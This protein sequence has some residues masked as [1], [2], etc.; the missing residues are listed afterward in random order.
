MPAVDLPQK[1][2]DAQPHVAPGGAV[3]GLAPQTE[4]E[5]KRMW[6]LGLAG[7]VLLWA[8]FPPLGWSLLAW[9]API[10]WLLLAR[11]ERLAARRPYRL[12]WVI[13]F[14]HWLAVLQ[15]IRL[16]HWA[17][18][19]GWVTLAAY[20]AIYVPLFVGLTRIAVHR[21][22][23]PL[24][25]AAPVVWT[26]L[27]YARGYVATGF[28]MALLG[29][30]QMRWTTLIQIS[31]LF[32]AYGVTFLVM[33]VAACLASCLPSSWSLW[34]EPR[35]WNWRPLAPL[36]LLVAAALG[37][38]FYRTSQPASDPARPAM[39]AALIQGWVDTI[40]EYDPERDVR[41]FNT[42]A[43][44]SRR[45]VAA[46]PDV[47]A[48]IWPEWVYTGVHPMVTRDEK[49]APPPGVEWPPNVGE[50]I[51]AMAELFRAKTR[52]VASSLGGGPSLVVG[53]SVHHYGDGKVAQHNSAAHITPSGEVAARY[54]KMHRVMFGE[55]VPFGE[56][57][58]WIYQFTP[59]GGG[60]TPGARPE[61]FEVA[62]LRLAPSICFES[63]V[64]HLIRGH[65][66]ELTRRGQAPDILVNNT[67]DGWFWGSSIL[68]LHL[69]C[70]VFRA[71]EH[72]T[73]MLI[74]ANTGLSAWIDGN[75]HIQ[76]EG[77]R[78]EEAIL[79]ADVRPDLRKS[80]Y[81]WFGDWLAAACL[82]FCGV[83]AA[84]GIISRFQVSKQA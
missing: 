72:R 81:T 36:V 50:N 57:F 29:H 63:T 2:Q 48:I 60:L 14:L 77:A 6:V 80:F 18:Y 58:P 74:A 20:V 46:H 61:A 84:T 70:G 67:N 17:T 75:G 64:P 5:R 83:V 51:D 56:L 59:L 24:A 54:D 22:R 41:T 13:G 62:G 71:V 12:L 9:L 44:L 27:E 15:G 16:A 30:T 34:R 47:E 76:A 79:I 49:V 37:Y 11:D 19:F 1:T 66:V 73:P 53:V 21:F 52:S 3:A 23:V 10:P 55:Y 35:T 25:V 69:A 43:E 28:S 42:Y 39:K 65:I 32:G 38:G 33:F 45:A 31:D 8:S 78:F 26:G 7:A 40:F 82:A 4:R 68:D